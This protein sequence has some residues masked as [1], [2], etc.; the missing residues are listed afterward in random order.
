MVLAYSDRVS[1]APPY[2]CFI[3]INI[4]LQDFHLLRFDFPIQFYSP[5]INFWASPLSLATTHGITI[6]FFS[7]WYLDV[8]VPKVLSTYVVASLQLAGFPHSDIYGSTLV[9]SSP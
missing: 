3:N 7:S 9:C 1:P 8:S 4:R 2:S 5:Y 6:V